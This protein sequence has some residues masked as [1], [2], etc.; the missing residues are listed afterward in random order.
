MLLPAPVLPARNVAALAGAAL[1]AAALCGP[2]LADPLPMPSVDFA[3]TASMKRGGTLSLAHSQ[4]RMRVEMTN[5]NVPTPI[6]GLIDL[7]A[8]KMVM[9]LPSVPNMAMEI[10]IPKEYSVGALAGSGTKVG[11]SQAAGETCDV[12][13]VDPQANL[14]S[15]TTYACITADGIALRTEV[16]VDGKKSTIYEVTELARAP[17]DPKLF[18]LPAGAQVVKVPKG[19]LGGA[20][21]LPGLGGGAPA[22]AVPR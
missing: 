12:W 11:Q 1:S 8:R 19:K 21:G 9:M 16:E 7:N 10:D 22:M 5:P 3:L 17:Q 2:A 13:Q 4:S 20:L 14:T 6:L 15:A 18:T